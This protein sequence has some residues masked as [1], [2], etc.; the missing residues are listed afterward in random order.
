MQSRSF[1]VSHLPLYSLSLSHPSEYFV[2]GADHIPHL[3]SLSTSSFRNPTKSV[4]LKV[5]H[6]TPKSKLH[7]H[8][9]WITNCNYSSTHNVYITSGMDGQIITWDSSLTATNMLLYQGP[10]SKLSLVNNSMISAS[11]DGSIFIYN[12]KGHTLERSY[13]LKLSVPVLD[14]LLINQSTLLAA[15]KAGTITISKLDN[16]LQSSIKAHIGPIPK[17]IFEDCLIY[18]IGKGDGYLRCFDDR[19]PLTKGRRIKNQYLFEGGI[20]DFIILRNDLI[21]VVGGGDGT[22]ILTNGVQIIHTFHTTNNTQLSIVAL[23]PY[24]I[25]QISDTMV[26]VGWG[27]GDISLCN[28][29]TLTQTRIKTSCKNAIRCLVVDEHSLVAAGDDGLLIAIDLMS[30]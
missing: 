4:P 26:A 8:S 9:D 11:Y 3:L 19:L 18:S 5:I 16:K 29:A 28:I 22:C 24:S 10:I 6:R 30:V 23:T 13:S 1:Q 21:F 15:D 2:A 25:L 20:S 7:S 17:I 12:L 27:N 14:A